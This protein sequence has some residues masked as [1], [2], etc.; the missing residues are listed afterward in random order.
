MKITEYIGTIKKEV[1]DPSINKQRKRHLED[2][3]N[4]LNSYQKNHPE[5]E[6]VPTSLELFCDMN[7]SSLEC[8]HYEV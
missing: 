3:L 4:L 5:I 6:N 8:R 1:D 2:E 7:P